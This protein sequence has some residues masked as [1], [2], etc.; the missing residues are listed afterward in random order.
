M[1]KA[2]LNGFVIFLVCLVAIIWAMGEQAAVA[3][4]WR[5]G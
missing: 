2:L 5:K 4:G 1:L 3:R